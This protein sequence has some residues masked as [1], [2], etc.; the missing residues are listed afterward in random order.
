MFNEFNHLQGEYIGLVTKNTSKV[1][2]IF[3]E[4]A[5]MPNALG[6][7]TDSGEAV[8]CISKLINWLRFSESNIII[9]SINLSSN[10]N[11]S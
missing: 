3:K 6:G 5:H 4:F 11:S 8:F 1:D 7:H 2:G 10:S 9:K